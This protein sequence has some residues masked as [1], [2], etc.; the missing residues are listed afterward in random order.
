MLIYNK[1]FKVLWQRR[2][3]R[4]VKIIKSAHYSI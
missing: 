2:N 4:I 3:L 1:L